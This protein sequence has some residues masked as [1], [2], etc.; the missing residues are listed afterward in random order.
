MSNASSTR[1]AASSRSI[2]VSPATGQGADAGVPWIPVEVVVSSRRLRWQL[3]EELFQEGVEPPAVE[4]TAVEPA[5]AD[6]GDDGP[7]LRAVP[8][9][10]AVELYTV[11]EVAAALRL[12]PPT[13]RRMAAQGLIGYHPINGKDLR[14]ARAD[15]SAFLALRRRTMDGSW[16]N[17]SD[18]PPAPLRLIRPMA[19][20]GGSTGYGRSH[21]GR[22]EIVPS[23]V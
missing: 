5:P 15:L 16:A 9:A 19:Q 14:F 22:A 1:G 12:K 21:R 13:V 20:V 7:D 8:P 17:V 6:E 3:V 10:P 23:C 11:A 2:T 4:T 18:T